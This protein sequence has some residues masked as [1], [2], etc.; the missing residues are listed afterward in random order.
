[1]CRKILKCD[2]LRNL[3][4]VVLS[5][6]EVREDGCVISNHQ[7]NVFSGEDFSPEDTIIFQLKVKCTKNSQAKDATDPDELYKDHKGKRSGQSSQVNVMKTVK[8]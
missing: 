8:A 3:A 5:S 4:F 2:E 7:I 6:W 1:M